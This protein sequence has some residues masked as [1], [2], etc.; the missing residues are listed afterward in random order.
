MCRNKDKGMPTNAQGLRMGYTTGSC[1]AA[2]AAAAARMLLT[3]GDVE[4][5]RLLTPKGIE[6]FLDIEHISRGETGVR[7]GVQKYAGDDPDVTDGIYVYAVAERTKEPGVHIEG[8]I[9]VGRVTRPGLDQP[10]GEAAINRVPRQMIME[11]VGRVLQECRA[12]PAGGIRITVEIP[13]GVGLA[14]KTFNPRLG[15]E[16]GISVLGTSGIVEPM[17]EEALKETIRVGL[18]V[19]R[20]E[21]HRDVILVPG[22]YGLDFLREQK[23]VD[24]DAAVKCSNFIGDAIDMAAALGFEEVLLV[25]NIGKLIKLSGGIFQ[26]HSRQ[27]DA[28]MELL[29]AAGLRAGAS[30][31]LLLQVLDAATTEDA[32]CL[33]HEGGYLEAVMAVVK[34]RIDFYLNMRAANRI[35]IRAV[36]FS[37]V[38]GEL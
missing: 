26:T 24:V 38:Y 4:Q 28:R 23:G 27:A 3:G 30:R 7:C 29:A 15:I 16:G 6:L 18:S 12:H 32:L 36:V 17:S 9:G 21:G 13:E 37:S 33:L 20:A 35:R 25:G 14:E 10:V 22:N 31:E 5:V 2:A 1:A 34:E 8:G 19:R 11:E